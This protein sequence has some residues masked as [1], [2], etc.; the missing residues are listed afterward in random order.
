[1][2]HSSDVAIQSTCDD[3]SMCKR[4][5][6]SRGYWKDEYINFMVHR[7]TSR[8]QPEISRG[9]SIHRSS[10]YTLP[11]ILFLYA[12]DAAT[13]N[14]TR[15]IVFAPFFYPC[16]LQVNTLFNFVHDFCF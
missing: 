15:S 12:T 11:L 2:S 4:Y 1:M 3:A 8:K 5:A 9:M 16:L 13:P 7:S 10:C 14:R 6:V